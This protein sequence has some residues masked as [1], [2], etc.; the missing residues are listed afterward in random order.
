MKAILI[1]AIIDGMKP[2]L[3]GEQLQMLEDTIV[4]KFNDY[5]VVIHETE[6]ELRTKAT[7]I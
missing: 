1:Q 2:H 4:E 3:S 7:T 6:E 5:D